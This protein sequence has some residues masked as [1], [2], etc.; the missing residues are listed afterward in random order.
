MISL[1]MIIKNEEGTLD[2]CLKSIKDFVDEI[3]VVDTGSNDRSKEIALKYTDKVFDFKWCNDFAKARNFS[4][5]KAI[6]SW[7]LVLDGDEIVT[8]FNK[9]TMEKFC[10]ENKYKVGR[11]FRSNIYDDKFGTKKYNERVNRLFNKDY[12]KYD[13]IIHEQIVSIYGDDYH[14]ENINIYTEHIGYSKEVL[15]KTNKVERNIKLLK[16]ALNDNPDDCYLYYQLGKAYFMAKDY[17]DAYTNFE[18]AIDMIEDCKYEYV[19]D[20]IESYG[21]TIINLGLYNKGLDLYK[22][23]KYYKTSADYIFLLALI[24][25]NLG[26]FQKAAETFLSC[27]ECNEGKV[28]GVTSFLPFYNIGIIFECLGFKKEALEYYNMCGNYTL[29]KERINIIGI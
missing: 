21:Y 5:S 17:R 9:T 29:A 27:T 6:N 23:E 12:F 19:E 7:V 1:C 3:I 15:N 8:N 16:I 22:Y 26:N 4:I 20:L 14:T 13:G 11:I 10:K 24:Q 2:K 28:E 25:M 18:K